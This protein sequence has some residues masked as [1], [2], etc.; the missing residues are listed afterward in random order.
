MRFYD[1]EQEIKTLRDIRRAS[2][3]AAQHT[4]LIG[5]DKIIALSKT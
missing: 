3:H 5:K 1:R 2:E 4:I